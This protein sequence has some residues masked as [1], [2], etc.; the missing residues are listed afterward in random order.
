MSKNGFHPSPSREFL[1]RIRDALAELPVARKPREAAWTKEGVRVVTG[2]LPP[3]L[4][5]LETALRADYDSN[6]AEFAGTPITFEYGLEIAGKDQDEL[7]VQ[8]R[9]TNAEKPG[10][11]FYG[12]AIVKE[13]EGWFVLRIDD[14]GFEDDF[15]VREACGKI[16][17]AQFRLTA[18]V[19]HHFWGQQSMVCSRDENGIGGI[20][21]DCLKCGK[22]GGIFRGNNCQAFGFFAKHC[23]GDRRRVDGN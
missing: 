14:I 3:V 5:A 13:R 1:S 2:R 21:L 7:W 12:R 11:I 23:C 15:G 10:A 9:L 6:T 16:G 8:T 22:R 4:K 20:F 17:V 19:I 18:E